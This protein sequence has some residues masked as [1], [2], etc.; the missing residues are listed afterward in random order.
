MAVARHLKF[1]VL[2]K[3]CISRAG[4]PNQ[5]YAKVGHRGMGQG[6]MTVFTAGTPTYLRND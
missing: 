4:G 6:Y 2:I 5:N 3:Y 1:C